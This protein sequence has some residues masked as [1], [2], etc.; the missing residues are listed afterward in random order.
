M[1]ARWLSREDVA[2]QVDSDG[3]SGEP[4]VSALVMFGPVTAARLR[5]LSLP[6]M[7]AGDG[8]ALDTPAD[9]VPTV[10][11]LQAQ[12]SRPVKVRVRATG[13]GSTRRVTVTFPD[14]SKVVWRARDQVPD[15]DAWYASTADLFR[16]LAVMDPA[17]PTSALAL[18]CDVPFTTAVRW[19]RVCRD[20]DLLPQSA[21][22]Q[23]RTR[24]KPMPSLAQM[25]RNIETKGSAR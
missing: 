2:W 6:A 22:Q 17:K 3:D 21:R 23:G 16:A 20:R 24:G 9:Q 5:G 7:T 13:E 14:G 18:F 8:A 4:F 15:A 11:D 1:S 19:V 10:A 25:K 12:R